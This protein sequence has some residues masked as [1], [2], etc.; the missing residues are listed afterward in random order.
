MKRTLVCM[1]L[2]FSGLFLTGKILGDIDPESIVAMWSFDE[3]KGKMLGDSSP[4]GNHGE[5]KNS[6][7]WEA[8]KFDKALDFDG[9][10][11]RVEVPDSDSLNQVDDLTMTAWVFLR[12]A[13][14]SGTWNA[15]VGKNPYPSGY[16]MW[17]EIPSEPCGLVYTGAGRFD[18]R[19]GVQ[20][21]LKRWYHLAFT[22]VNRGDM[23]FFIDGKLVK[24]DKSGAGKMAVLNAP[25]SIGGQSP[26]ILD[27]LVDEIAI[28]NTALN[29]DDINHLMKG[30]KSAMSVFPEN[31]LVAT[32]GRIKSQ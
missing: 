8:G 26:Q 2:M 14:T 15:L 20:L 12:R 3:G 27:G 24:E 28:F 18:N 22:R 7:A 16:L 19:S 17:I 23:T 1:T 29:E 32:W 13:V 30:F 9:K 25:I 11:D 4:N 6:P 21:D 31:R 5:L 10:D